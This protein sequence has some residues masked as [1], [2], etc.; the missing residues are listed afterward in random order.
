[1]V[2]VEPCQNLQRIGQ[3]EGKSVLSCRDKQT[4]HTDGKIG[5][6]LS[7]KH[8]NHKHDQHQTRATTAGNHACLPAIGSS[9]TDRVFVLDAP[10]RSPQLQHFDLCEQQQKRTTRSA[11]SSAKA[12]TVA[13]EPPAELEQLSDHVDDVTLHT[14]RSKRRLMDGRLMNSRRSQQQRARYEKGT[15]S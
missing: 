7:Y 9:G 4:I 2:Q 14:R 11:R 15:T 12:S 10:D 1:M 6:V 5:S 3:K 8:E 13:C